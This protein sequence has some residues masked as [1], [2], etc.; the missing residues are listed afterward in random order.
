MPKGFQ[1]CL[2]NDS[3]E[4]SD[5]KQQALGEN[6]GKVGGHSQHHGNS[7]KQKFLEGFFIDVASIPGVG[8][9]RKAALRSFGIET[10]ADVTRRGVKQVK[11]FGDHLT[12]AVID[13]KASCERRFVFRPNEAI[14]PADRQAVMAKMTA[15]RHRLESTLTVG[16]TELQR[17]R[18]HAPARTMPLME[19]LRQAAE[20]LA[21]A[22]AD[23]SRC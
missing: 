16:A 9:A 7:K 21:Q 3:L 18:L 10:A 20:K 13:W 22:Q 4:A 8:P 1:F 2:G 15:K 23:L 11:G 12:Q 6:P 5:G 19:P 17:F 14:T